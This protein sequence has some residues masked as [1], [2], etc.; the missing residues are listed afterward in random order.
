[1]KKLITMLALAGLALTTALHAQTADP[2]T[3]LAAKVVKLQQGPELD[4]LIAQLAGST[5]Q[6]LIANWGPRLKTNVAKASQKKASEALNAELKKY[7][8]DANQL[9]GKQV[10]KVSTD[11]LVPAYAERFTL[12]EL[13]QIAAFFESPAIKKYQANS[14]ELGNMFVQK[15]I[16]ASRADVLA[17]AKQFDDAALKIVGAPAAPKASQ[18]AKK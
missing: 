17:R 18:P 5:T 11:V 8:D 7:T 13:Q 9:I 6:E 3:E 12:E 4:R 1:M 14:P 15:L 16:D 2:K 10:S